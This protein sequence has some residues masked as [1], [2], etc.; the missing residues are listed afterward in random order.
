MRRTIRVLALVAAFLAAR[1]ASSGEASPAPADRARPLV[2]AGDRDY[3]PLSYLDGDRPRGLD[4]E[5]A[6]A[7]AAALGRPARVELLGWDEAQERLRAGEADVLLGMSITEARRAAYDFPIAVFEHE[8]ALFVRRGEARRSGLADLAGKKVGVTQGGFPRTIVEREPGV[9]VVIVQG[10]V[11]GLDRLASGALDAFAGDLWVGAHAIEVNHLSGLVVAGAPFAKQPYSMAVRK[12]DA[13]TLAEIDR[14][15][16]RLASDGTIDRIRERWRPQEMVFA[17]RQR[18]ERIYLAA[19]AALVLLVVAGLALWIRLLRRHLEAQRL[20]ERALRE[21]EELLRVTFETFPDAIVVSRPDGTVT[22]VNEVFTR[23]TGWSSAEA[24]GKTTLGMGIWGDPSRRTSLYESV[25][26][27]VPVRNLEERFRSRDGSEV[28]GLVSSNVIVSNGERLVLCVTR[29]ITDRKRVEAEREAA[30]RELEVLKARLEEEN[31]Y[32]KEEIDAVQPFAGLVG[33]SDA[34]KYVFLRIR[35][36]A[37]SATSVLI[38]GETGVGKELVARAIHEASPRSQQ[39]FVRVNCAALPASI[40]ESELFGHVAGAFTGATR[41]RKGRFELA[42]RGTLFLDEVGELPLALQAKLLRVLQ[43]GEFERVGSSD[44][45]RTDVRI[46]AATNRSL[47]AEV[48]AGRFREDLF[49]RLNVFPVTV[50][51]LRERREDIALLVKHLVPLLAADAGKEIREV[52]APALR[53]LSEYSWPG[54][55]REL[56]NVLERAVLQSPDGILRLPEALEAPGAPAVKPAPAPP[57]ASLREHER[58]HILAA[59]EQTRGRVNGPGG[60]AEILGIN[61]NTLRSR[62]KKLGIEATPQVGPSTDP[63]TTGRHDI[64]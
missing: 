42:D 13:A 48:A 60:A 6:E 57:V 22:S 32:L 34:L 18:L 29:D 62:M 38:E 63:E 50:P 36:V 53:S 23:L 35:Q 2:F 43:E 56:R 17:S 44:T 10:Y 12:G 14:A 27:G 26:A 5:V 28:V 51:P 33:Q 58:R 19:A 47:K 40:V 46:I 7:V 41:L 9:E 8:F 16:S 31:L 49:Y 54:N 11:D 37:G 21:R 52:A 39:P 4:V 64:S 1:A 45:I 55:V 24:I 20:A 59:L 61:P 30:M 25:L 15:L 3:R